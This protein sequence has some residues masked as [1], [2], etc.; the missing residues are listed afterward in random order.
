MIIKTLK[1]G[2]FTLA[3][4]S[5][6]FVGAQEKKEM[7][8]KNKGNHERMFKHLD[9]DANGSISLEEFK[10]KRM[11]D[12]SKESQ[13]EKRFAKMDT[14]ANGSIDSAEFKV[15]MDKPRGA[16]MEMNMKEKKTKE[17]KG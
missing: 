9:A 2:L 4:A 5:F 8:E 12:A 11:K 16:K 6:S 1:V 15:A 10:A 3:I 7:K 13:I 17:N 14:D